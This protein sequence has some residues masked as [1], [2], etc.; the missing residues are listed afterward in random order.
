MKVRGERC[1]DVPTTDG[2]GQARKRGIYNLLLPLVERSKLS[3]LK[4]RS[5]DKGEYIINNRNN[6]L[7][8]NCR[9]NQFSGATRGLM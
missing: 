4:I 1:K 3:K 7:S 5:F 6:L 2:H 8:K 9:A